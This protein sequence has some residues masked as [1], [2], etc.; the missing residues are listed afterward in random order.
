MP[1]GVEG[2]TS[3]NEVSMYSKFTN[4]EKVRRYYKGCTEKIEQ[5]ALDQSGNSIENFISKLKSNKAEE[6]N[7]Y[8]PYLTAQ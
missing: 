7:A 6:S 5:L 1:Y 2:N 8:L 3:Q 4:N